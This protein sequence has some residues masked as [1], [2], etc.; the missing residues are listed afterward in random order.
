MRTITRLFL[1]ASLL[2]VGSAVEI[3]IASPQSLERAAALILNAQ[4]PLVMLNQRG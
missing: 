3:P 4:R 2:C 1:A